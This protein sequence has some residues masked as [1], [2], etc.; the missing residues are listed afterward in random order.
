LNPLC[1]HVF[2]CLPQRA[3]IRDNAS[4]ASGDHIRIIEDMDEDGFYQAV[5]VH[6]KQGGKQGLVPSNFLREATAEEID[7]AEGGQ[8]GDGDEA[9]SAIGKIMVAE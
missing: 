6:G 9:A 8:S 7:A 5:H 1:V 4:C 2:L 3:H